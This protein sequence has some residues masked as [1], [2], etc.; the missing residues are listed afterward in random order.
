MELCSWAH[1]VVPALVG[2]LHSCLRPHYTASNTKEYDTSVLSWHHWILYALCLTCV[3]VLPRLTVKAC[4]GGCR[5]ADKLKSGTSGSFYSPD[6]SWVA[7]ALW[8]LDS[9]TADSFMGLHFLHTHQPESNHKHIHTPAW[10]NEPECLSCRKSSCTRPSRCLRCGS[11]FSQAA[12]GPASGAADGGGRGGQHESRGL[13]PWSPHTTTPRITWVM[14][15]YHGE[16]F[17][18]KHLSG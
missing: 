6:S 13:P 2:S 11:C 5:A 1:L 10:W 12:P 3:C 4:P 18:V 9:R 16:D 15:F 8:C 7:D 14:V 17:T